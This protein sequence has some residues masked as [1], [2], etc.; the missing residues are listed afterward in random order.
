MERENLS[1]HQIVRDGK[2]ASSSLIDR[3]RSLASHKPDDGAAK[4]YPDLISPFFLCVPEA[5]TGRLP[6]SD[7][8]GGRCIHRG[9]QGM[10]TT[11]LDSIPGS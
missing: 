2:N 6:F 11:L 8:L 1:F 4:R 3:S 7:R 10:V 5:E 9:I